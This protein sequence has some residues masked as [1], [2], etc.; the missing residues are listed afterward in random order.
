MNPGQDRERGRDLDPETGQRYEARQLAPR[1]RDA[2]LYDS[3]LTGRYPGLRGSGTRDAR[4]R[5]SGPGAGREPGR[6]AMLAGRIALVATIVIGQLWGLTVALNAWL[7]HRTDQ[8]WLLLGFEA[9][10]FV[11]AVALSLAAPRDH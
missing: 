9:L 1:R 8:V 4:I 5:S 7:E 6:A 10:S 3:G 2:G 11:L